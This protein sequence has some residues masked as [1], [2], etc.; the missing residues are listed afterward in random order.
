MS[1]N[2]KIAD[3]Q[4]RKWI[5]R[6]ESYRIAD[7]AAS[8]A[9]DFDPAIFDRWRRKRGRWL[10]N[11]EPSLMT[12]QTVH[13]AIYTLAEDDG[14][15]TP[16]DYPTAADVA[17]VA[18]QHEVIQNQTPQKNGTT[19]THLANS[20]TTTVRW[21]RLVSPNTKTIAT[22]PRITQIPPTRS[23]WSSATT[24]VNPTRNTH[25]PL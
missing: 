7:T 20:S 5:T 9:Q 11:G 21:R 18:R 17:E 6:G 12:V 23:T 10:K 1:E 2:P 22:S 3:G 19:G 25:P 16:T 15:P 8:V 4:K 13:T 14:D 24:G